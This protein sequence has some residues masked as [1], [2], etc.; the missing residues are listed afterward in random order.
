M[1]HLRS[2]SSREE[3]VLPA[4]GLVSSAGDEVR[5]LV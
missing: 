1:P 4:A 3:R 2:D 5:D